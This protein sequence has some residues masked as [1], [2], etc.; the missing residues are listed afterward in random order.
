VDISDLI[1]TSAQKLDFKRKV[2]NF[3]PNV[4]ENISLQGKETFVSKNSKKLT[5]WLFISF[6]FIILI[7]IFRLAILQ[8]LNYEKFQ[9]MSEKNYIRSESLF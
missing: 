3:K 8:I 4:I 9:N 7:F 2:K 6:I 1:R 5:S